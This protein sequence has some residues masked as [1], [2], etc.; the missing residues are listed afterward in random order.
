MERIQQGEAFARTVLDHI[1]A[2]LYGHLA[3]AVG[4]DPALRAVLRLP[5]V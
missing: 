4:T 3:A 5:A 1:L 2:L